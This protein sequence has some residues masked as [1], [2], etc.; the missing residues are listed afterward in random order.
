MK[1]KQKMLTSGFKIF[2]VSYK[3]YMKTEK[4]YFTF[5][6][7]FEKIMLKS[8]NS[9]DE[10]YLIQTGWTNFVF[11][12][13]SMGKFYYFRFPRNDFFSK[14]LLKECN[15]LDFVKDKISFQT[16]N[17]I[18]KFDKSRPYTMHKEIEGKSL[19]SCFNSLTESENLILADDICRLLKEFSLIT[20]PQNFERVSTFLDNLSQ[21]SQNG[22]DLSVHNPLKELEQKSLV[23]SHGDFNPG[24][25]ILKDHKLYAVIDFSFSGISNSL[26]D[27]SRICGRLPKEFSN[28]LISAYMHAFNENIELKTIA[29]L[30]KIWRYVE[31]KYILYI[32]QNH[33]EIVLPT[34]I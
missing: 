28:T 27:L 33:P 16:P 25:L 13:K 19:T 14:A 5:S 3:S 4:T 9:L 34:L 10:V 7:N 6:D 29:D 30:E 21:V 32:K 18:L 12:V 20:P 17:L 15:M 22:Y 2:L 11:R 23:F 1:I 24:N 8:L 26:T 31:E